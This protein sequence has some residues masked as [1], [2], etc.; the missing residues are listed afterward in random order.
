MAR[1]LG[2][3]GYAGS[4]KTTATTELVKLGWK[5]VKMA[6]VLKDMARVLFV[7]A[8]VDPDSCLDGNLKETPLKE[9]MGKTPRH[10]MQT[11]GTEWGRRCIASDI[12]VNLAKSQCVSF[13]E[14]GFD[15]VVDDIRFDNE[16]DMIKS[17][18]GKICAIKGRVGIAG[19]HESEYL[20]SHD[21][22]IKNDKTI[23]DFKGL[24]VYVMHK[25]DY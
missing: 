12:W 24:V 9:L 14:N 25:T 15:V 3:T 10:V 23:E 1:L 16:A 20:V 21:F 22:C 4:G 6:G 18:G 17:I 5:N 7:S 2:L 19:N 8:G 11:L 13:L